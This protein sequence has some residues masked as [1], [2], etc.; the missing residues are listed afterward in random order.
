MNEVAEIL[1]PELLRP[2]PGTVAALAASIVEARGD[3]VAA[4]LFYG[5]C[6]RDSTAEGVLDLYVLVDDYRRFHGRLLPAVLNRLLPPTVSLWVG[7]DGTRAKVAVISRRQFA[8]R[9][10]PE[11]LDVTLWSRFCQ[12]AALVHAR[13]PEVV[14]W[15]VEVLARAASTAALWAV[16]LGP[17]EATPQDYWVGLF[18]HTYRAELRPEGQDRAP[19]IHAAASGRYERLLHAGLARA[20]IAVVAGRDGR[21]RPRPPR[22]PASWWWLRRL[23]GKLLTVA[24]LAKAS[25]TF[26]NGADYIVWKIERH[27]GERI[28]LAP[29]QRRHPLVA[30]PLILWRLWRRGVIR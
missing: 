11:S 16:R 6:L 15:T 27:T 2:V 9:M 26:T 7:P 12:P 20:G 17:A 30:A 22:M 23:T 29:W 24:R 8:E 18:H 10:R 25:F 5:S 19:A 14:E 13:E 21:L 3:A 4:I 1:R 28:H